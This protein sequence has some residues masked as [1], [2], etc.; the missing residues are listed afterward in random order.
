MRTRTRQ[1]CAEPRARRAASC[2][3]A[4]SVEAVA[5]LDL[6]RGHA[7]GQQARER[8]AGCAASS[9]SSLAARV[10]R[11]VD[12]D[13]AAARG[14]SP[15]SWRPAAAARTRRAVAGVDEVRVAVDQARR[16][17]ARRR[18][19]RRTRAAAPA[20]GRARGPT[21]A[22]RP[23]R[24]ASAPSG[25]SPVARGTVERGEVG[26]WSTACPTRP[27]RAG[28][29]RIPFARS[30]QP[31]SSAR[32]AQA[33]VSCAQRMRGLVARVGVAHHARSP[34]RSTA[35]ARC[36]SPRPSVPSQT[37]TTPACCE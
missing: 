25:I 33:L 32:Q 37:M 4:S 8:A 28:H 30:D 11:T 29:R 7:F 3:S 34:G 16:Q 6:D 15:R 12:E 18:H 35:R 20:A 22:M 23:S 5:G 2:A 10:A 26:R 27:S 14:R 17:P 19:P 36:A 21:Q 13:A 31:R 1:R 24:T 9:S